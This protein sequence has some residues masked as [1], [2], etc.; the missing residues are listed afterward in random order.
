MLG[1]ADQ[2]LGVQDLVQMQVAAIGQIDPDIGDDAV[3]DR[4]RVLLRHPP[5]PSA[6]IAG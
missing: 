5:P 1:S 2:V 4:T 6:G 3:L